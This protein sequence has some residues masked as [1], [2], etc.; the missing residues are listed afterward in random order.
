MSAPL[1]SDRGDASAPP[2]A[3]RAASAGARRARA[4]ARSAVLGLVLV[5]AAAFYAW[6][7]LRRDVLALRTDVAERLAAADTADAQARAR[8]S[9]LGN[10]QREM[11]AKVALLE[12]RL[13]E[14]Q[15]QQAALDALYRELAPS[16]EAIALTEVEQVLSLAS[17]QL[18]LA[19]NVQAALA[20]LQL[21]DGKLARLDRPQFTPLRRE[22]A[23]DMDRLKAVPYVDVAGISLKL[24]Q[25]LAGLD[26]LPLARD[27][28]LPAGPR[29][30]ARPDDP[31]WMTFLRSVWA[32]LRGIVRIEV[33]DRPAAPLLTPQETY[34]LRENLRLRLL[35]AR[36][37]LLSRDERAFRADMTA[38]RQWVERYFDTRTQGV[39]T[40]AATLVQLGATPMA[41]DIPDL[42]R[43]LEAVRTLRAAGERADRALVPAAPAAPTRTK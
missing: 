31:R 4:L 37:A 26:D 34:F 43:S 7:D 11:Q 10:V 16:R 6:F 13:A 12:A 21:A 15:S 28:R 24:D 38:A 33:S 19:G 5:A 39:Q 20:A 18:T 3:A 32:D 35:A 2:D 9:D 41:A 36:L 25:A 23:R 8:E 1:E 22:L 42:A 29:E 14:S 30:P 27:E 17:Q 40:L